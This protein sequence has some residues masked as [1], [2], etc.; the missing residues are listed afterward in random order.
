MTK[1][2]TVTSVLAPVRIAT[3]ER[4]DDLTVIGDKTC[5]FDESGLATTPVDAPTNLMG[6][7]GFH[8]HDAEESGCKEIDDFVRSFSDAPKEI[9]TE[10]I[11]DPYANAAGDCG[12]YF[13]FDD[14]HTYFI[15]GFLLV[16]PSSDD[17]EK[18]FRW[19]RDIATA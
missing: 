14:G 18:F 2:I 12:R 7:I 10:K 5:D 16:S 15:E 13:Q 8:W 1:Y 11:S 6:A 4:A 17:F 9:R 3:L 19:G